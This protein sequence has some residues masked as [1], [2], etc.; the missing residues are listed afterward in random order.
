MFKSIDGEP[1]EFAPYGRI[2][3]V[4]Q[5]AEVL[6]DASARLWADSGSTT[7]EFRDGIIQLREALAAHYKIARNDV[8][9]HLGMTEH[10][11]EL[12]DKY[13]EQGNGLEV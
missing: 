10:V 12:E 11:M 1:I 7:P 6:G 5:A 2:A 4:E 13:R 8:F 9:K 3:T